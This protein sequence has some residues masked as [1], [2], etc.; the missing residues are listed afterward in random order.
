[1]STHEIHEHIEH[2]HEHGQKRIGISMAVM[3]VLL[4]VATMLGHRMHTEEVLLQTKA[5]DQWSYFQ[6]KNIR[7]HMYG[8]DAELAA[9]S[10]ASGSTLVTSFK[11]RGES[12]RKE[13]EEIKQAAEELE[14]EAHHAAKWADHFDM[15]EIFF[16]IAI[17]LSSISLLV[18]TPLYLRGAYVST[19]IGLLVALTVLIM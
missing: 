5:N 3:A 15:S 1:M 13:A 12:Q 18:G 16:E 17:V 2:A 19:V 7:S 9:L 4:A 14:A 6:A 11:E 10:G 8:A